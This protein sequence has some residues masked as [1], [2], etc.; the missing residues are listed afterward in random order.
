MSCSEKIVCWCALYC[1]LP[2]RSSS[3][4]LH[5]LGIIVPDG[6]SLIDHDTRHETKRALISGVTIADKMERSHDNK[7]YVKSSLYEAGL[8][9]REMSLSAVPSVPEANGS[10]T[11]PLALGL[12]IRV[13]VLSVHLA[14]LRHRVPLALVSR[15]ELRPA[16][17]HA[18]L[19]QLLHSRQ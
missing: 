14:Q 1:R 5:R 16:E 11:Q 8:P 17:Q 9:G 13:L 15:P 2:T 18:Q 6:P 7:E 19:S 4:S 10:H 3:G 12:A